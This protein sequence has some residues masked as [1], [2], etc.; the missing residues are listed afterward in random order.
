MPEATNA[1]FTPGAPRRVQQPDERPVIG[2]Q[3]RANLRPEAARPPAL[4]PRLGPRAVHLV[5]VGGRSAQV[6]D[7]A[8]EIGLPGHA[9]DLGQDRLLAAALHD[10]PLVQ[11][12]R[13][14]RT[15]AEAAAGDLD[16]VPDHLEG[17]NPPPPVARMRPPREG[18]IVYAVHLLLGER[19]GRRTDHH[20]FAAVILDE[21]PGVVGVRLL[22]DHPRHGHE[23]RFVGR[24][25]FVAGENEGREERGERRGN[26]R[27]RFRN[28]L[29]LPSPLSSLPSTFARPKPIRHAAD[30]AQLADRFAG[31]QAPDDLDQRALA[32]AVDQQVG[33]GVH[34]NR[35][36]HLVAP[37]IVVGQAAEAGL[38]AAGNDRHAPERLAGPLAVGQ[39]GSIGP[40]TRL[41][42]GAVGVVVA[43]L[44]GGRIA[45]E[46]RVHVAGAHG[47]ADPRPAEGPPRFAGAPVGLAEDRHAKPLGLEHA[48]QQR[49]GEAGVIDVGVAGDKDHVHGVPTPGSRLGRRHRQRPF[50]DRR[51]VGPRPAASRR[52]GGC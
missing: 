4:F 20:R 34:Q 18:Q 37:V 17:R 15:A 40:Q 29:T 39:R 26:I 42:V 5:H 32:H 47:E 14:E 46:H 36:P 24:D 13:T 10:P 43:D 44:A 30:V 28:C 41:A 8:G 45:I 25:L 27:L 16:R 3:P 6:A 12:E 9:A 52:V 51:H 19:P 22:V 50:S 1:R 23:G 21:R 38:D 2:R 35:T 7:R 33:L 31:R 48:A 11:R 49:H